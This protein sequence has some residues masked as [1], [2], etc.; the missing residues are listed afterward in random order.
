MARYRRRSSRSNRGG[1]RRI[2]HRQ[3]FTTSGFSDSTHTF[4][5][6]ADTDNVVKIAV[7][8]LKGDDQTI[9]RTRGIITPFFSAFEQQT[10]AALGG[11]VLPN[12]TAQNSSVSELP[13]PLL[14]EDTTDWFVWHPITVPYD[15]SNTGTDEDDDEVMA[16]DQVMVDSKAKRIMEASESVV[17]V[18]GLAPQAAVTSKRIAFQ[19]LLRTLVGY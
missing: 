11:I 4:K 14:D 2:E 19:Y 10:N 17:W 18:L 5:G 1:E 9:L 13:N 7:D 3:W 16:G 6:G 15:I 12:K 8:P